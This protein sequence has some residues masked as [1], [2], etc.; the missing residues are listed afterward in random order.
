MVRLPE[1][2]PKTSIEGITLGGRVTRSA[3]AATPA[4][5][6]HRRRPAGVPPCLHSTPVRTADAIVHVHGFGISGTYLEPTAALLAPRH[7]TYVP[8][9]PGMGRSMRPDR[10]LDLPASPGRCVATATRSA[11]SGR[12]SSA[13]R[14]AA[15]SSSRS[16]RRSPTASSTPCWSR[17][18]AARTTNRWPG[19]AADGDRR[20]REPLS[21]VADR[22]SRLPSLRRAPEPGRC[23]RR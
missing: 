20:P 10:P 19:A 3:R 21:M 8:D 13:T 2:V 14:S 6:G 1:P 22:R 5:V 18:P 23:S 4:A 7:R 12:R 16:R 15:R 17:R 9:L 11:S